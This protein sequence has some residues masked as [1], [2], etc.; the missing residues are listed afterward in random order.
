MNA[1]RVGN[2]DPPPHPWSLRW[3]G[4]PQ[5]KATPS[6]SPPPGG[7]EKDSRAVRLPPPRNTR[8]GHL[9]PAGIP[10]GSRGQPRR[11]A[12]TLLVIS[13]RTAV[14][15]FKQKQRKVRHPTPLPGWGA[16]ACALFKPAC[17]QCLPIHKVFTS[18]PAFWE[19]GR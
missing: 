3:G 18:C 8:V 6:S 16:S 19:A 12:V 7:W 5:R 11:L 2:P 9:C 1:L 17:L 15:N 14:A 4:T 10:C 13:N